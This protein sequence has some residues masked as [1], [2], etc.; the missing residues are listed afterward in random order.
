ML[1]S[2]EQIIISGKLITKL[3]KLFF[4]IFFF[5]NLSLI[6][7]SGSK[8]AYGYN[9]LEDSCISIKIVFLDSTI[10]IPQEITL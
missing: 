8:V 3:F 4:S 10:Q 7:V 1:S 2:F 9:L 6:F 5:S